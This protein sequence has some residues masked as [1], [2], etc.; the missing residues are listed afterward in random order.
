MAVLLFSPASVT[1]PLVIWS[2]WLSGQLNQAAAITL[3]VVGCLLPLILLY[4]Y[5]GRRTEAALQR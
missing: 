4:F 2:L 5:A 1:L 3:V